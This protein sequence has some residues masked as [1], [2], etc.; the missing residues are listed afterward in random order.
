M[1]P[2]DILGYLAISAGIIQKDLN[3]L[4][5]TSNSLV[6]RTSY[7]Q[8]RGN[9]GGGLSMDDADRIM[10]N[11]L[12]D[13]TVEEELTI[14]KIRA[15]KKNPVFGVYVVLGD[16]LIDRAC[17]KSK[18]L[19]IGQSA[20]D[21]KGEGIA[22]RLESIVNPKYY[23][24]HEDVVK[25]LKSLEKKEKIGTQRVYTYMET[26]KSEAKNKE[27]AVLAKYKEQ[28]CELPPLNNQH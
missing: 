18:I 28:H 20:Y 7:G 13:W 16:K 15:I 3:I 5:K 17:D 27:K 2:T 21:K 25:G 11:E 8:W 6:G 26:D 1:L 19:Y 4:L 12:G 14:P 23:R 22:G 10:L 9:R 24:Y